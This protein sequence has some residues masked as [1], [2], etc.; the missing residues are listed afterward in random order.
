MKVGLNTLTVNLQV[1]ES[2]TRE[3]GACLCTCASLSL[4][5]VNTDTW[6]YRMGVECEA[7]NLAL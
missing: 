5:D 6:F 3:P 7:D 2:E 4:G 1:T